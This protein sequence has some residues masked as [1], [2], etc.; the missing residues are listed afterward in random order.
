MLAAEPAPVRS[1][2]E[3][4]SCPRKSTEKK[5]SNVHEETGSCGIAAGYVASEAAAATPAVTVPVSESELHH[6]S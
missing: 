6:D 1:P 5:V 4:P 3:T 2:A